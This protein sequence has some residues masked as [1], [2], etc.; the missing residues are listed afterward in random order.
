MY[1]KIDVV[2]ENDTKIT[3]FHACGL[4]RDNVINMVV[5][6]DPNMSILHIIEDICYESSCL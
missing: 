1:R 5:G 6:G 3:S 2:S 4:S